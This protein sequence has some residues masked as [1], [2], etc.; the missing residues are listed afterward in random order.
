MSIVIFVMLQ[1]SLALFVTCILYRSWCANRTD[2]SGNTMI[3]M[4]A[5][6]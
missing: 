5:I 3:L 1:N 2:P 4:A 6:S